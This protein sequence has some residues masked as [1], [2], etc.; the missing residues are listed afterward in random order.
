MS[1][2]SGPV[3][4]SIST[5]LDSHL[6]LCHSDNWWRSLVFEQL[7]RTQ[8]SSFSGMKHHGKCSRLDFAALVRV[9]SRNE[10]TLR[11]KFDLD[12]FAL[13]L[14]RT[15]LQIRHRICHLESVTALDFEESRFYLDVLHRLTACFTQDSSV[16]SEVLRLREAVLCCGTESQ[17]K[18]CDG[19][20]ETQCK[21]VD[22]GKEDS[23]SPAG[24]HELVQPSP[25][26]GQNKR[27]SFN[28]GDVSLSAHSE[29][30]GSSL[31]A[32]DDYL[33]ESTVTSWHVS[34]NG[35]KAH[36]ITLEV[37][38]DWENS[39]PSSLVG[40]VSLHSSENQSEFETAVT[41]HFSSDIY[42]DFSN[43]CWMHLGILGVGADGIKPIR[44]T[45]YELVQS[46]FEDQQNL[47]V[48]L[49]DASVELVSESSCLG[50]TRGR[51]RLVPCVRFN[52]DVLE[53]A[54]LIYWL[55]TV[56]KLNLPKS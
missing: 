20:K 8:Q 54:V 10:S 9:L 47:G 56:S 35:V 1:C 25:K 49:E 4:E 44:S 18:S 5:Y 15:A 17:I 11:Y 39:Q 27:T 42:I 53:T 21:S 28:V 31:Y 6:P 33:G 52:P 7:T 40:S 14:C 23:Y 19:D 2:Y 32:N 51:G 38:D 29:P 48:F 30:S 12:P 50:I 3:A 34:V 16:I 13:P 26:I 22:A 43:R 41:E 37:L 55:F 36:Q 45:G 24:R 46:Y